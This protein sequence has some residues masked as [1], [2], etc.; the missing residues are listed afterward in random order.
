MVVV[1]KNKTLRK[2]CTDAAAATR[3][4][5]P[6]MAAKIDQRIGELIAADNVE[7]MMR[8]HVGRCH[9]LVADRSGQYA[10]DLVGGMRM[11]FTPKNDNTVQIALILDI[12][13]YH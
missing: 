11:I 10:L 8:Y 6:E 9:S 5:G 2:M 4:Y 12:K 1:Y 3:K 13:D 7:Q